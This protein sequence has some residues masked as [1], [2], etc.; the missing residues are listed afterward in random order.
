LL[1]DITAIRDEAY[2]THPVIYHTYDNLN[3][4]HQRILE[5]KKENHSMSYDKS[6][7]GKCIT[8]CGINRIIRNNMKN[9]NTKYLTVRTISKSYLIACTK[10]GNLGIMCLCI[11][12]IDFPSFYYFDI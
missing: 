12:G 8:V 5:K 10:P 7:Q 4:R 3:E 1:S 11:T 2:C 6:L 9:K